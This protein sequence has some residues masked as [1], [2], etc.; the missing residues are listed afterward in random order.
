MKAQIPIDNY[1]ADWQLQ[2]NHESAKYDLAYRYACEQHARKKSRT[3]DE[4]ETEL[5]AGWEA[6]K[7]TSRLTWEDARQVIRTAWN[8]I[9]SAVPGIGD[10]LL[11]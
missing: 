1:T 9:D 5:K 8:N 4:A 3:F 7:G 11:R 2:F 10:Q 6:T